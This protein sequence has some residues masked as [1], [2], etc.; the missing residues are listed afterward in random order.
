MSDQPAEEPQKIRVQGV[1]AIPP[2][3]QTV[4][5]PSSAPYQQVLPFVYQ[6][7]HK[8]YTQLFGV[9]PVFETVE[10]SSSVKPKDPNCLNIGDFV[11]QTDPLITI[12]YEL[13]DAD[14]LA[15]FSYE[16]AEGRAALVESVPS[17]SASS[18][19]QPKKSKKK[20]EMTGSTADGQNM[21]DLL[22]KVLESNKALTEKVEDLMKQVQDGKAE[23]KASHQR[24]DGLV[25][26]VEAL[27][28]TTQALHRRAILDQARDKLLST[29]K[30]KPY[31]FATPE[32]LLSAVRRDLNSLGKLVLSDNALQLI[33]LSNSI[34]NEGSVAAYEAD[35]GVAALSSTLTET[36]RK[37]LMEVFKYVNGTEHALE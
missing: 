29:F 36:K 10:I 9:E 16:A 23:N 37:T 27:E 22:A 4:I 14:I 13:K 18:S 25:K 1:L 12:T 15:K 20:R 3:T 6:H 21:A 2:L 5:F 28:K 34:W 24:I 19:G 7:I 32:L 8:R 35:L 11:A 17:T 31:K 30:L 33:F 26:R